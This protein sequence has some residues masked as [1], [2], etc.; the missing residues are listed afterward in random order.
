[1]LRSDVIRLCVIISVGATA[2]AI[3]CGGSG[4]AAP[5]MGGHAGTM[6]PGTAGAPGGPGAGGM[7]MGMGMG[8]KGPGSGSTGAAGAGTTCGSVQQTVVVDCGYPYTSSSNVLTSVT[9]NESDILR[10]IEPSGSSSSGVVKLFYNDEHALTL[11]V[12]SV[13]VTSGAGATTTS[14]TVS[15]L[16]SDPGSVTSPQTGT[17]MLAGDESG[18]DQSLRPMWPVLYLTDVTADPT[19]R[20]GD[21]QQGG[22]PT[23]PN[24][25]YGTWKAAVRTVDTTVSPSKVSITPD[26]DPA[27]NGWTL[28]GP[29][30]APQGLGN[31]GY[32]AE[33]AWSVPFITGHSYR[34]QVLIHDGDQNQAGGDSGEACVLFC[35]GGDNCESTG[36]C[37]TGGTGGT[38][39]GP[40]CPSGTPACQNGG[41]DGPVCGSGTVCVSGCCLPT[42]SVG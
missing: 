6:M 36:T 1:M 3:G 21:W 9:F 30:S 28:G 16:S 26:A 33:V 38:G 23:G 22:R 20:A 7:G 14:Y 11:G 41:P 13:V 17:T 4:S 8:M 32:G 40:S 12:R 18:L 29:D 19:S 42:I 27:K 25:V 15:S 34:V 5:G 37:E 10:A 24:A 2:A 31:E 35:S 39:G